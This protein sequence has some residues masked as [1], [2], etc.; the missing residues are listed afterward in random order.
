M[1][2]QLAL[3]TTSSAWATGA[4]WQSTS[5]P[6]STGDTATFDY[7]AGGSAAGGDLSATTLDSLDI[8]ST[9]QNYSF[10]DNGTPLKVKATKFQ[11]GAPSGSAVAGQHSGRIN[12]DGSTA[13]TTVTV[14]GTKGS[15]T[16]T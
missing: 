2:S 8:T 12:W 1:A 14:Y 9:F 15:S 5:A 16:D 7:N 6:A 3:F 10:G 4:N 13:A 11:I